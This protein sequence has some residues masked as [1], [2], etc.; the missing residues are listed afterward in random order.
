MNNLTGVALATG[1]QVGTIWGPNAQ[2]YNRKPTGMACING[3]LY[4][5]VQD[6]HISTFADAPSASI[7]KS[8]N[9]GTTWT[10][11]TQEPMFKDGQFTTIFFLDFG[12]NNANA[13]DSYVYA[14]GLDNNWRGQDKL[15]L[16]RVPSDQIQSRPAWQFYTG[17]D[18]NPGGSP[19]WS[20]VFDTNTP[21]LHDV[22][23]SIGQGGVVYDKPLDRYIYTSWGGGATPTFFFYEAPKP[24]GP[25]ERFLTREFA[26]TA[27]D[28]GG[29]ATTIP[30]KFISPSGK[31]MWVQ[32]NICQPC[33][34]TK[35]G[36]YSFSLREF[37]AAPR[38]RRREASDG[39]RARRRFTAVMPM[40]FALRRL[41]HG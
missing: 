41:T 10:W 9:H 23:N 34:N 4:L 6:L 32:S 16:A 21:V 11:D 25:W 40:R 8:T 31:T 26:N 22:A 3:A 36:N 15:Y 30:S 38:S 5:A 27:S 35:L 24:W 18:P 33:K 7:S 17:T 20:S 14:Y 2:N 13:I 39:R 1:N 19:H 37:I 28:Y 29:Y 12:K